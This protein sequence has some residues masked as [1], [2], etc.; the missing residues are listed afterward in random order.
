MV[1][2]RGGGGVDGRGWQP[3]MKEVGGSRNDARGKAPKYLGNLPKS[4]FKLLLLVIF[5]TVLSACFNVIILKYFS[6]SKS[7][8]DENSF[9]FF[10][11]VILIFGALIYIFILSLK[12][13]NL[14]SSIRALMKPKKLIFM[15]GSTISGNLT[16]LVGVWIIK[17]I[18]LSTYTATQTAVGIIS[19]A[20]ASLLFREKLGLFSYLSLIVACI[21][22][23]I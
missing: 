22:V 2:V 12:E 8:T 7:V 1:P 9:F 19:S 23:I 14:A 17:E 13:K 5:I 20:I 6:L 4:N 10:T 3:G 16:S 11:N 15:T 21:T 18:A